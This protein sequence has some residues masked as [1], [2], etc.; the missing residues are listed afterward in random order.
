[1]K[2]Q[3]AILIT[4]FAVE[5]LICGLSFKNPAPARILI[6]EKDTVTASTPRAAVSSPYNPYF[7]RANY[8]KIVNINM[9]SPTK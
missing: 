6:S 1:M 9:E 2:R 8:S 5:I 3:K 4:L 7:I